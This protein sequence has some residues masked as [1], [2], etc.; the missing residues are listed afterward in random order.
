[1]TATRLQRRGK[2]VGG[3]CIGVGAL[4][5]LYGFVGVVFG[6]F[7]TVFLPRARVPVEAEPIFA[8][9]QVIGR[10]MLVHGPGTFVLGVLLIGA[11]VGLLRQRATA[12][13]WAV[14]ACV[15]LLIAAVVYTLHSVKAAF[16]ATAELFAR[17]PVANLPAFQAIGGF[18]AYLRWSAVGSLGMI[19]I[20]LVA[21]TFAVLS[22]REPR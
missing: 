22:L 21:L 5:A 7:A 15:A 11:G 13:R 20:P 18:D 9:W 6:V 12:I 16:P 14:V 3:L 10:L 1:M 8:M 19:A 17:H 2:V 4:A